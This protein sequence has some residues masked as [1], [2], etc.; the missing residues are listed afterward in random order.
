VKR[1]QVLGTGCAKCERLLQNVLAA[2][3]ELGVEATVEKIS[4][5][6]EI[7]TFGAPTTPALVIDGVVRV[8]GRVAEVGEI[9]SWL[10]QTSSELPLNTTAASSSSSNPEECCC[11]ETAQAEEESPC[12]ESLPL[13]K[14]WSTEHDDAAW[15]VGTVD[16]PAGPVPNVSTT[17]KW[18]DRWGSWKARWGIRRM[19]YWVKPGLYTV[20]APTKD[21][22][23]FVS[24]NYK[25]SFDR[26]RLALGGIDGWILVLDT[27][28]IN[29]WCAAGKGTFGTDELVRQLNV[30]NLRDVVSHK[31]LVLPQLGAP[32]VAA[33]EVRK[34]T[35]FRVLYGPIRAEDIPAFLQAG[36]KATAEM[37]RVEF[38]LSDRL[39]VVP[40]EVVQSS[41][42]ALLIAALFLFLGGLGPA[43][44]SWSQAFSTGLVFAV[45]FLFAYAFGAVIT[46]ALLPWL[47]GRP[48]ALKGLWTGMG[49]CVIVG[50][51]NWQMGSAW[52]A[53]LGMTALV[54]VILATASFMAMKFTGS[55]TYTSLSGVRR[56]M[57]LA[58]P[59]QAA[60]VVLGMVLLI[61]S[62]FI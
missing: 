33:H 22:T 41:K 60:G 32:G 20:G 21:S 44:Y 4:D 50:V 38:P 34:R 29:V 5:M 40:V 58:V 56:E 52:L 31:K 39:A 53:P 28:G 30:T 2:V 18:T 26:L 11:G 6:G 37:R 8:G 55:T 46:P 49:L 27:K 43:G 12:C 42:W 23:V 25:M 3:G 16:T 48:L 14:D 19:R 17:L 13:A 24:A 35:G 59:L 1:L 47:P 57:R 45:L 61:T 15:V 7:L 36:M 54:L 9:R 51:W 10:A 62:R